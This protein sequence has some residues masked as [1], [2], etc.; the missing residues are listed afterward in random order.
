MAVRPFQVSPVQTAITIS[1][2]NDRLKLIAD[3]VMPRVMV[4]ASR[5]KWNYLPPAQ[6]FTVPRT[7]V[8]RR[9]RLERVEFTGEERTDEIRDYGL[10]DSIPNQDITD[11][12][13]MRAQGLG[14]FDPLNTATELLT[15]LILIDR[16]ARVAAVAQDPNNYPA[17]NRIVLSGS[18]QLS[19]PDCDVI[20]TLKA[21]FD[22]PLIFRPNTMTMGR[23]CWG[24]LSSHPQLVNAV[25]GN[26]SSKG[27]ITPDQFVELFRG[28]GLTQLNIGEA[29]I[30][31]ARPGQVPSL[32]RVWGKHISLTYINP[33][34]RPEYGAT[35]GMTAQWGTR[36][37]GSWEDKN[38]GLDGGMI[39]RVGER[40]KEIVTAPEAG[41]LIQNA[42]E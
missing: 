23:Q 38:V 3:N 2:R 11:A 8:G 31:T 32:T 9:G 24:G 21:S 4:G 40:V 1:F 19:H 26:V 10:E 18:D 37:A 16:E 15:D 22:K 5:F 41:Y 13:A 42:V 30:N 27:I 35:W 20:G 39:V 7:E 17:G 25:K 36:V 29:F 6:A 14:S 28:E 34:A 12:Q 33:V